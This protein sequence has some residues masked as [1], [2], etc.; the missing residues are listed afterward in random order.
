[1]DTERL[2]LPAE[3]RTDHLL[4]RLP[5]LSDAKAVFESYS[6][7]PDVMRFFPVA[8]HSSVTEAED[9]LRSRIEGRKAGECCHWLISRASDGDVI[10]CVG[11]GFEGASA[12]VGIVLAQESWGQGFGTEALKAAIDAAFRRGGK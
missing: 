10:G 3:I 12:E 5:A 7:V 4:L 8:V 1:M 6:G 9:Y 2:D 11:L